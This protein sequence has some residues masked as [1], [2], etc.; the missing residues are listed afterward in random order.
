MPEVL[1]SQ[2]SDEG[3]LGATGRGP[4][5]HAV[6]LPQTWVRKKVWSTCCPGCPGS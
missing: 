3:V 1:Q 5:C 6:Q 2:G 4:L